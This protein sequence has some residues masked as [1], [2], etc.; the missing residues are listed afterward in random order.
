MTKTDGNGKALNDTLEQRQ[1]AFEKV[2]AILYGPNASATAE[3]LRQIAVHDAGIVEFKEIYRRDVRIAALTWVAFAASIAAA[4]L[5]VQFM[6][7]LV[8]RY[9]AAVMLLT[10]PVAIALG[11]IAG[12]LF[13]RAIGS[14]RTAR[15]E[16]T[17]IKLAEGAR[18]GI[19]KSLN[20]DEDPELARVLETCIAAC[21]ASPTELAQVPDLEANAKLG[22]G[23]PTRVPHR[24]GLE[25]YSV[26]ARLQ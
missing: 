17:V 15:L 16:R 5:N 12:R 9:G 2:H 26:P 20:P 6:S 3:I 21:P 22:V 11:A 4:V 8:S 18:G 13:A 19:L 24:L 1:K 25:P 10:L 14:L 23:F 7:A